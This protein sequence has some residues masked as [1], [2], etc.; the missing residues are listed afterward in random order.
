[1]ARI[2]SWT[3][4]EDEV[5]LDAITVGIRSDT[6]I[7]TVAGLQFGQRDAV[8]YWPEWQGKGS[9]IPAAMEGPMPV[10]SALERA[11]LLCAQHGFK[12]VVVW[13]QHH[14]LWDERWGQLAPEQGL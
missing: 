10:P 14:E 2:Y 12:R 5:A 13:L 1:M 6:R 7:L 8:I 3:E 9:L 11:E 4:D